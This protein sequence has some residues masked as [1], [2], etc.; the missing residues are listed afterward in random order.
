MAP[1]FTAS[2]PVSR[3]LVRLKNIN[4][5]W[6]TF[7]SNVRILRSASHEEHK[8]K[9]VQYNENQST[10]MVAAAI[11]MA[12][13][14]PPSKW[15]QNTMNAI[16]FE[17]IKYYETCM[18]RKKSSN[19]SQFLSP[20]DLLPETIMFKH[21]ILLVRSPA[22]IFISRIF[23]EKMNKILAGD[24]DVHGILVCNEQSCGIMK[25]ANI[26]YLY[27]S[28]GNGPDGCAYILEFR[29]YKH[30]L[31]EL[32]CRNQEIDHLL[33][34]TLKCKYSKSREMYLSY[35]YNKSKK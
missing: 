17:G 16:I 34:Y 7:K 35:N 28:H 24:D 27:D 19:T 30:M 1:K 13:I 23:D 14:S 25:I 33:F 21:Q 29:E 6:N 2:E 15:R 3:K 5:Q 32:K 8:E 12:H 4:Y 18:E 31:E 11:A 22:Q 26:Y 20:D 10:A 9:F